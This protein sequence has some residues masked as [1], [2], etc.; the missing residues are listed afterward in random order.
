MDKKKFKCKFPGFRNIK[1]NSGVLNDSD[2]IKTEI[3]A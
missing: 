2:N 1:V 3:S